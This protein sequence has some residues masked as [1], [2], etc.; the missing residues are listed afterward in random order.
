MMQ[1]VQASGAQVAG[2]LR[3]A[4]EPQAVQAAVERAVA[5]QTAQADPVATGAFLGAFFD[6]LMRGGVRAAVVSP[7][8]RSTPLAMVA[9]EAQRRFPEFRL[10]VDVDERGAAFVALG[11]AKASGHP[12]CLICTSGTAV[13]N[14][15]PAVM[16]AA[17][18]RVP[19]LVLTGDRPPRL[20]G[21]GAPQTCDQIKAFGSHVA[22]FRQMP[23]PGGSSAE[24]AFARQ[25]AREALMAAGGAG[26]A[27][28]A[29]SGGCGAA[30]GAGEAAGASLV[31]LVGGQ[32]A[33][34]A[35]VHLNFPFDEPL[36]PDT[37]A[38]DLFEAG[39]SS[40]AGV[41][42]VVRADGAISADQAALAARLLA[43]RRAVVVAGEGSVR[44][45]ADASELLAWARE[46]SLPVLADPLSGL[47]SFGDE[48]IIDNY[49]NIFGR[50]EFPQ[51]EAIVRFGR[52]PVSKRC[53]V[54]LAQAR[55]LQI[56][57]DPRE[58]RDFNAATDVL[59]ACGPQAF[60]QAM[61]QLRASGAAADAEGKLLEP[62]AA[63]RE[64]AQ[65]WVR[66]NDEECARI[67]AADQDAAVPSAADCA[68]GTAAG[69][70]EAAERDAGSAFG[71]AAV[72][73]DGCSSDAAGI[74]EG[75]F[76]R[77]LLACAPEGS[78]LWAASSM[79]VRAVDTFCTKGKRLRLL[80]NRGLNGIDGTLSS[81]VGA[82]LELGQATLLT[83]D[84]A[85]LHDVNAFALQRELL[86]HQA[87]E[88][89][90][91]PSLTVVLLNNNG[92]AIF[93]MLPQQ[94]EDPYFERLFL[95]PQDVRFQHAAEAFGVPY[96]AAETP[97]E[98]EA[99]YAE[100]AGTP[101]ISLI[102]VRVP[103]SGLKERY[104]RYW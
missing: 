10:V 98:L 3:A 17:V 99:A 67:C 88:G 21:L 49:D 61:R 79:S 93:D 58:T 31:D 28:G 95:T 22:L 34:G 68:T 87:K 86:V 82:A 8:S 35:P 46:S 76:V 47:R 92:G 53:T 103:L 94:S 9:Y 1:A 55:P 20:Q 14:Y 12:V 19:L 44:T 37:S 69:A 33:D 51:P 62:S 56:V 50:S 4:R 91:A 45:A 63:Q 64:F 101:G 36:K 40:V 13:A 32:A 7:G 52:W 16:E 85:L 80:C 5:A 11:M 29:G 26:C 15:Y 38:A 84:L 73:G 25:A 57:V 39:R 97:D 96:R 48:L 104:A 70:G 23:L 66:A 90:P 100:L 2:E 65:A 78:C 81:A 59:M 42:P 74:A 41:P 102:E 6:E 83:G 60:V 89:E 27:G 71:E 43:N 30:A 54:Q 72:C 75:P 24:I 77:R 18:S